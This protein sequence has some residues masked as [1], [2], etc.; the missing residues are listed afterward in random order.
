MS[1]RDT[2]LEFMTMTKIGEKGNLLSQNSFEKTLGWEL[3]HL[4]PFCV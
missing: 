2:L 1:T 3:A 4:L